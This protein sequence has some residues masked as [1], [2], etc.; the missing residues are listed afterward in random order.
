MKRKRGHSEP[1]LSA[2]THEGCPKVSL[3]GKERED[4]A[5]SEDRAGATGS[6]KK[7]KGELPIE[8]ILEGGK[9]A[10]QAE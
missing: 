4:S 7:K 6:G 2:A 9:A 10:W 5:V 8:S 3:K 1:S